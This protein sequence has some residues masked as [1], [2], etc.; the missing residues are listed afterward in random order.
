MSEEYSPVTSHTG[1]SD[2]SDTSVDGG[3]QATSVHYSSRQGSVVIR[4]TVEH[5]GLVGDTEMTVSVK[6]PASSFCAPQCAQPPA[7]SGHDPKKDHVPANGPDARNWN[8]GMLF[9]LADTGPEPQGGTPDADT[10]THS[11]SEADKSQG[12]GESEPSN[13]AK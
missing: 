7:P 5:I 13:L 1:R 3:S 4:A 6:W 12:G 11:T 8:P 2:S 9:G 10:S